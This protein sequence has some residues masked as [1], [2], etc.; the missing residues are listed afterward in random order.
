[1]YVWQF[2]GWK[3]QIVDVRGESWYQSM[4]NTQHIDP[5]RRWAT[6]ED[7]TRRHT[8]HLRTGNGGFYEHRLTNWKDW[9]NVATSI[10]SRFLMENLDGSIRIWGNREES[11]YHTHSNLF[12]VSLAVFSHHIDYK[13][14]T[15]VHG[16]L[17]YIVKLLKH[18]KDK[19][20]QFS[21]IFNQH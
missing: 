9:K 4:L 6:A 17:Q 13:G 16:L 11:F 5:W 10:E 8:C 2:T 15:K 21:H 19:T 14:E 7:H 20:S 18:N 1:M 12:Y 3:Y